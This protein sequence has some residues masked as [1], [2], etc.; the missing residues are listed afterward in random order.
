MMQ[1]DQPQDTALLD[2]ATLKARI[3]AADLF[4][5]KTWQISPTPF[6]LDR[7]RALQ[8][9]HYIGHALYAFQK[10][11][12]TL[13][14]HARKNLPIAGEDQPAWVAQLLDRGKPE[15][16]CNLVDLEA[17]APTIP[18]MRPDI[19]LT[20][21]GMAI[22]EIDSQPGGIGL[23]EFLYQMYLEHDTRPRSMLDGFYNALQDIAQKPAPTIA[24]LYNDEGETYWHEFNWIAQ[25][26]RAQGKAVYAGHIKQ[27]SINT[28]RAY[29]DDGQDK[30]PIDIIY[31]FFELYDDTAQP[32]IRELH[33][34]ERAQKIR[35]APD[36]HHHLEEKLWLGLFWHPRLQTFWKKTLER[37]HWL[38]LCS[39]IPQGWIVDQTDALPPSASL[40]A[41]QANG[42]PIQDWRELGHATQK[43][44]EL[45]LKIS[46]FHE[47]AWGARGV[48]LGSD[49]SKEDW[50]D[51]LCKAV[52]NAHTHPHLMQ[53]YAKPRTTEHPAY[54]DPQTLQDMP[55]RVRLC[56]YFFIQKDNP[57]LHGILATLCP[58]NKKIIHGMK[59]GCM[60][61]T[62]I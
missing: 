34:L 39:L 45:I 56:P 51:A 54:K 3:E 24:I 35:I 57:K 9:L 12:D 30:H 14:K 31:R 26:L 52:E 18:V 42:L 22:T 28:D 16:I 36:F 61:P 10:A 20:E 29:F 19:L 58:R 21:Q 60:L 15:W 5:S 8:H 27:L 44:R 40:W 11:A 41:P 1:T 59:D 49:V 25:Q 6:K 7:P 2:Y 43:E 17:S 55:W 53:V 32:F 33:A 23:T 48:T 4:A 62:L 38:T 47:S 50:M 46:G 37:R 13:Y